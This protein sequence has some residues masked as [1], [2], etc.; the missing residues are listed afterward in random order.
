MS[1][2]DICGLAVCDNWAIPCDVQLLDVAVDWTVEC[3]G[4]VQ[5]STVIVCVGLL[6]VD[7]SSTAH[8]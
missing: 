7:W 3:A 8:R 1:R 6:V 2:F 5:T 4:N